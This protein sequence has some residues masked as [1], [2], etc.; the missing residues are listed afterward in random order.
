MVIKE[1]QL[2]RQWTTV[3]TL[4]AS[5]ENQQSWLTSQIDSLSG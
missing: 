4:L 2:R 3:Q 5:L 1:A